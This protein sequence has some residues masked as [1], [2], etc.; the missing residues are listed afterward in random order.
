MTDTG[1]VFD[2]DGVL[3]DTSLSFPAVV[4]AAVQ[5]MAKDISGYPAP[6]RLFD[7]CHYTIARSN[8]MFNDDYDIAWVFL[9]WIASEVSFR[10]AKGSPSKDEWEKLISGCDRSPVDWC[11]SVL[12]NPVDRRYVRRICEEIYFGED[13]FFSLRGVAPR[14]RARGL[15]KR[16]RPLLEIN[17]ESLGFPAGIYTGRNRLELELALNLLGWDGFPLELCVTIDEGIS[18]PSPQGLLVLEERLGVSS[19]IFF[20]DSESDRKAFD[21]YG[22]GIFAP[23]G[24]FF[25]GEKPSFPDIRTALESLGILKPQ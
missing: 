21:E 16:E 8:A 15:W 17:W 13:K 19:I 22:K 24:P 5:I 12:H 2:V 25:E 10:G 7:E 20:G 14:V 6:F 4:S 9:S 18:K 11:R 1:L 23:I 3:V